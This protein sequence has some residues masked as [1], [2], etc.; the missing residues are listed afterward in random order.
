MG[1]NPYLNT[2]R[3]VKCKSGALAKF[4]QKY[5]QG[6]KGM[7]WN[8]GECLFEISSIRHKS[9]GR[10]QFWL[11]AI[12]DA[13]NLGFSMF[14]K[15]KEHLTNKRPLQCTEYCSQE[16]LLWHLWWDCCIPSGS[17]VQRPWSPFQVHCMPEPSVKWLSGAQV[18][19][20]VQKGPVNSEIG[21]THWKTWKLAPRPLGQ[22]CQH[23]NENWKLGWAFLSNCFSGAACTITNLST[24]L[25]R[26]GDWQCSKTMQQACQPQWTLHVCWLWCKQSCWQHLHLEVMQCKWIGKSI[27]QLKHIHKHCQ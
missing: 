7:Q 10:S 25:V 21:W 11:L 13:I 22:V 5:K 16:E 4:C 20:T 9:F 1:Q 17:K 18:C 3:C 2:Y 26:L 6:N 27:T 23:H 8:P 15:L 19:N 12:D 14:L 24:C